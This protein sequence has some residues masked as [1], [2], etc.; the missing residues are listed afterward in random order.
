MCKKEKVAEARVDKMRKVIRKY[1]RTLN[2]HDFCPSVEDV[3]R[4]P[5][6]RKVIVDGTDE[7]F[8]SCA[9]VSGLPWL[10]ARILEQRTRKLFAKLPFDGKQS[11][12]LSLATVWFKCGSCRSLMDGS[13]A[14]RHRCS[15]SR[16][17]LTGEL[18]GLTSDPRMLRRWEWVEGCKLAFSG[19]AS[20]I[21]EALILDCDEDPESVTFGEMNSKSHRFALCED[22]ELVV[23]NW[24][25]AVSFAAFANVHCRGLTAVAPRPDR[26]R[27]QLRTLQLPLIPPVP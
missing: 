27:T 15:T 3:W 24:R 16:D 2:P 14:A 8:N 20:A 4:V 10:A 5:D 26:L 25:E 22:G 19:A 9:D 13:G 6:M 1:H 11:D 17:R 21:A 12:A 18:A 7:E 23:R